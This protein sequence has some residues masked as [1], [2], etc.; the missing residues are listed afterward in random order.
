MKSA[1]LNVGRVA[2][3]AAIELSPIKRMAGGAAVDGSE[4]HLASH[5]SIRR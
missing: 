3:R 4:Q 5:A 1:P 2:T